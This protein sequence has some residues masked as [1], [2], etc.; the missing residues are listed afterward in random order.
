MTLPKRCASFI[1]EYAP[2]IA[3]TVLRGQVK[4][5]ALLPVVPPLRLMVP[6]WVVPL[7]AP[8]RM[9]LLLFAKTSPLS[10]L[11]I[12]AVVPVELVARLM[13]AAQERMLR[14]FPEHLIQA[15][16]SRLWPN[17]A[18]LGSYGDITSKRVQGYMQ[19]WEAGAE[20]GQVR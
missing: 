1:G 16:I 8:M 14:D 3:F 17:G 9:P 13:N 18:Y 2:L 7:V 20:A 4:E 5:N 19:R 12:P 11:R 15:G 10:M 6:P